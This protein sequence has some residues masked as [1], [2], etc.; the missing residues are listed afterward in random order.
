MI[1]PII[2]TTTL[3]LSGMATWYEPTDFSDP[4]VFWCG[5]K[6]KDTPHVALP[7]TF[8]GQRVA[9]CGDPVTVEF[10]NGNIVRAVAWDA[11]P[12][13]KYFIEDYPDLPL[14]VDIPR[15]QWPLRYY[16]DLSSPVIVKIY[17]GREVFPDIEECR[18]GLEVHVK[19]PRLCR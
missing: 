9:K 14:L 1:A 15:A 19:G 3:T 12:L 11:G 8:Y 7:V 16:H 17:A 2:V 18:P 13:Y 10:P 5:E 6:A 4:M